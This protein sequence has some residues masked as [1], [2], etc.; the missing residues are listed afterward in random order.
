M[1]GLFCFPF[2]NLSHAENK[3]SNKVILLKIFSQI[4]IMS[5]FD[6]PIF[7]KTYEL[8]KTFH[9]CL[10]FFPK[11]EKYTLGQKIENVILEAME[12]ILQT[13]YSPKNTKSEIIRK[14]SRKIDLLK[15]LFRLAFETKSLNIKKYTTLEEMVIEIGK[16][17]GGWLKSN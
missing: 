9:E 6:I 13:I 3:F 8:Y 14:V 16:M 5:D 15:Y 17:V 2:L 12:L 10:R 1:S 4:S 7:K 11:Q